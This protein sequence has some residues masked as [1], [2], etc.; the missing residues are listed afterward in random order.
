MD[1]DKDKVQTQQFALIF[2]VSLLVKKKHYLQMSFC[3]DT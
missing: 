2:H 3:L 1:T